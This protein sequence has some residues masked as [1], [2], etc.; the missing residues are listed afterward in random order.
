MSFSFGASELVSAFSETGILRSAFIVARSKLLPCLAS[1]HNAEKY[2]I[3]LRNRQ[4]GEKFHNPLIYK[5]SIPTDL[6]DISLPAVAYANLRE[7][8]KRVFLGR[9]GPMVIRVLKN[10]NFR[11]FLKIAVSW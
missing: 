2:N 4:Y 11:L 6:Q 7:E 9:G 1:S 10:K 8:K 3:N 5:T